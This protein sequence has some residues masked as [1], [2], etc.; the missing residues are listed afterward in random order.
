MISIPMQVR[1]V[2][3]RRVQIIRGQMAFT[4]L[5]TVSFILQG[6]IMGTGQL[7]SCSRGACN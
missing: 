5:N 2:M 3:K 7:S 6:I 4:I 1:A